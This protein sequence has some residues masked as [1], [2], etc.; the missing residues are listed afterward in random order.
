MLM[1]LRKENRIG[2]WKTIHRQTLNNNNMLLRELR[3]CHSFAAERSILYNEIGDDTGKIGRRKLK[4][5]ETRNFD[6]SV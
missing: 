6:I 5:F 1:S 4:Y 2:F 3:F